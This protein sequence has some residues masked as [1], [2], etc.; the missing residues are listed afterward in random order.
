MCILFLAINK[1]HKYPLIICANRD[2]FHQRPTKDAHFWDQYPDMLAGKDLQA[3]GSWLGINKTGKFAAITNIRTG[4]KPGIGNKSRGE[5]VTC[6]LKTNSVINKDWLQ[7]NSHQ[8]NPFNLIYGSVNNLVCFN[9]ISNEQ[10]HLQDGFHAISNGNMDDMWPKMMSGVKQLESM[11]QS[12]ES[13]DR[14]KLL[15]MLQDQKPA[16]DNQLPSTGVPLIW[17]R[18]LSSIF[19]CNENY[20]TRS[21]TIIL[22]KQDKTIDFSELEY[23]Q[24]GRVMNQ[25]NY[26]FPIKEN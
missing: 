3:G 17:E 6:A 4:D 25:N 24:Q 13:F 23:D 19:I 15:T 21:S 22:Q 16:E 8:Y 7:Q 1:H 9:S 11:V 20:G 18:L 12:K 2:E 10:T 26:L 14:I 5:L